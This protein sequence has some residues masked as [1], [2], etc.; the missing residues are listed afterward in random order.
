MTLSPNGNN[1]RYVAPAHASATSAAKADNLGELPEWNLTDLYPSMDCR[2]VQDDLQRA[3]D[4]ARAFAKKYQGALEA[5][6]GGEGG[7]AALAEAIRQYEAMQEVLGRLI[8]YAGLLYAGD[9]SD[10]ACSK[11]YGDIQEKLTAITTQLLFF[12]LELNRLDDGMLD[13]ATAAE[14]LAYYAPWLSD[15]RKERQHQLEDRVEQLFHEKAV[16]GS[17]AW[18]RLFDETMAALRFTV[19]GEELSIEPTLSGM[20]DPDPDKRRLAADALG[21]RRSR[22]MSGCS[23]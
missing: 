13:A 16:T 22:T 8:S 7:G 9:T 6:V 21:G 14:G 20:L 2:D 19:D 17:G 3:D 5:L 15:L 12:E 1:R 18:N 4:D 23:R 11:F 10:P